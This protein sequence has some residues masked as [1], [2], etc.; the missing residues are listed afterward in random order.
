MI[1][2]NSLSKSLKHLNRIVAILR[3]KTAI[4]QIALLN[5]CAIAIGYIVMQYRRRR[6]HRRQKEIPTTMLLRPIP[7]ATLRPKQPTLDKQFFNEI[8]YL[9]K[10]MFPKLLSK[11]MLYLLLHT[12]TLVSR[13]FISI[14]VAKLEGSL[15]KSI[16][17]KH[18]NDFFINLL[19][20]ISIAIPATSCNSLI[21]YLESKLELELRVRLISKSL[22]MYF[23]N[24][25]YYKIA[26]KQSS[27]MLIDQNLSE[28][29]D[30]LTNLL[31]HLFSH[32]TKPILD[33][34]LI[35]FT[36]ISLAKENNYN[37]LL[38]S[39]IAF[40]VI[41]LTGSLLRRISPKFGHFAAEEA[42]RK[43]YLR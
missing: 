7:H 32:L 2:I 10:I 3:Q 5:C 31:V 8:S 39:F 16:V 38:P 29:V 43:G 1:T 30:K 22:K 23:N 25:I 33:I 15:V 4:K 18:S 35:T 19:K 34:T 21:K 27:D 28:D 36:L 9:I 13:T 24:R 6:A 20:W 14:Y 11:Q 26:L 41:M 17:K 37:Y 42:K 12:V 40:A